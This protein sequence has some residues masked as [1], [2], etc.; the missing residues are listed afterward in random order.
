MAISI[1][2]GTAVGAAAIETHRFQ[3]YAIFKWSASSRLKRARGASA[4][5]A[6]A[7]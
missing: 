7:A 2:I 1:A 6:S 5:T 4:A 3:L